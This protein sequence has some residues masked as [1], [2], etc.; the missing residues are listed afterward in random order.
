MNQTEPSE[1]TVQND[2]E[3]S[4]AKAS[5][6]PQTIEGE[7]KNRNN[8]VNREKSGSVVWLSLAISV[9]SLGVAAYSA[10]NATSQT[11][12]SHDSLDTAVEQLIT[13]KKAYETAAQQLQIAK[14]SQETAEKSYQLAKDQFDFNRQSS[15][16]ENKYPLVYA[17]A[18]L[19][20]IASDLPN[21]TVLPFTFV[22]KTKRSRHYRVS[23]E[24]EG[25]GVYWENM[26]P[27]SLENKIFLD[28]NPVVLS[29]ESA[30]S[31][32]FVI[33]HGVQPAA[34]GILRLRVNDE[35]VLQRFYD[36]NA[37]TKAYSPRG[38]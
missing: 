5:S 18:F 37:T 17:Q 12:I 7:H 27:Q 23:V 21:K 29:P 36:Y 35:V 25:F 16:E 22:N 10:V 2:V 9:I 3:L 1:S 20:A 28:R 19:D 8:N 13:A 11:S 31:R 32:P 24:S 15:E 34:V 33:W 14:N 26:I 6:P 38:N 4:K 30:H